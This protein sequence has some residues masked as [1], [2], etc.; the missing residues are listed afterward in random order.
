[1]SEAV[2]IV[3]ARLPEAAVFPSV[4]LRQLFVLWKLA[5]PDS[6]RKR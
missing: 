6:S 4:S 2:A 1:M 3:V 5:T